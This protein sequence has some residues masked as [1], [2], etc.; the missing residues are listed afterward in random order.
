MTFKIV[1]KFYFYITEKV[2]KTSTHVTWKKMPWQ[3]FSTQVNVICLP[4]YMDHISVFV[5]KNPKAIKCY[6]T[7][8]EYKILMKIS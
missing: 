4:S 3:N 6:I 8:S 2:T 5:F 7:F 1:T